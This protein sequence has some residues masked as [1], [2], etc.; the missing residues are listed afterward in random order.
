MENK[1]ELFDARLIHKWQMAYIAMSVF[2]LVLLSGAFFI[3]LYAPGDMKFVANYLFLMVA[4]I[5]FI[6]QLINITCNILNVVNIKRERKNSRNDKVEIEARKRLIVAIGFIGESAAFF[7]MSFVILILGAQLLPFSA[8][9]LPLR[10]L[11]IFASTFSIVYGFILLCTSIKTNS[12]SKDSPNFNFKFHAKWVLTNSVLFL[13]LGFYNLVYETVLHEVLDFTNN[14]DLAM[15]LKATVFLG[16]VCVLSSIF[17][18]NF[19]NMN[20]TMDKNAEIKCRIGYLHEA[21]SKELLLDSQLTG[22]L[23]ELKIGRQHEVSR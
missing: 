9:A 22:D 2:Y 19:F 3:C 8:V 1:I 12:E 11:N 6:A 14:H 7:G 4:C 21:V 13:L 17:L 5:S 23:E 16:Y 18:S 20:A 15:L 10:I